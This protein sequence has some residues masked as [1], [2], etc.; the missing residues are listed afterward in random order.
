MRKATSRGHVHHARTG[1]A[2]QQLT[3]RAVEPDVTQ[4]FM[5]AL[6][7]KCLELALQRAGRKAGGGRQ[8]GDADVALK[9]R[10]HEVDRAPHRARQQGRARHA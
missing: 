3:P 4:R 1:L 9:T 5:R 7:Q 2:Q 6:A 10:Q 8:V